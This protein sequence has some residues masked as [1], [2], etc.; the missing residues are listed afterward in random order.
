MRKKWSREAFEK[1]FGSVEWS[2][3]KNTPEARNTNVCHC[4]TRHIWKYKMAS[5]CCDFLVLILGK[6]GWGQRFRHG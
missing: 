3:N 1:K 4:S 6:T 2:Q 5:Q